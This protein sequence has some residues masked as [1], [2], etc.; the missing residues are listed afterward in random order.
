MRDFHSEPTALYHSPPPSHLPVWVPRCCPAAR[1]SSCY[2]PLPS[3]LHATLLAES[4]IWD[5]RSRGFK[6]P[7]LPLNVQVL[8]SLEAVS[9]P[10]DGVTGSH[11]TYPTRQWGPGRWGVD[12]KA[13][14]PDQASVMSTYQWGEGS[15][16]YAAAALLRTGETQSQPVLTN[17][18]SREIQME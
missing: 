7:A 11:A 18:P 13:Q 6:V 1:G 17:L 4:Q 8:K 10:A 12:Y 2:I 14:T 3:R 5:S 15:C 9:L 16:S